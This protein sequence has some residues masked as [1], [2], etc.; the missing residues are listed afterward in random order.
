MSQF[1]TIVRE[2][3]TQLA[4]N[5]NFISYLNVDHEDGIANDTIESRIQIYGAN[6]IPTIPPK[7]IISIILNTLIDPL[8]FLL[9][10]SATIATVFG[11]VFEAQREN[12][13]WIEGIAIWFTITVI[14]FIGAYNDYK[15]DRA[16]HKLTTE[17]SS[18]M[19]GVIRDGVAQEISNEDL[20]VGDLVVLNAGDKVPT[21]GYLLQTF[22]LGVDESALT[23]ESIIVKKSFE[24]DPWFR[25]G[26]V[27]SEGY[28][29]MIVVAVGIESEYGRTLAL[30]HKE[31][32]KTPLQRRINR[33]VK[34]CGIVAM[35]VS[36]AVF[37]ALM[38]NWA[39]ENPRS[40]FDEGPLKFIVFSISIL[41]VGLPE[42][43]PAAVMITLSYS[44]K[45]MMKD[46]L[47]VR[48]LSACETLGSTT[49]LLSDK[50]G[51][52]TENK[53][54]VVRGIFGNIVFDT[55]PLPGGIEDIFEEVLKNCALNSTAYI[56]DNIGIGSQ[57]EIA[58]L[59]F[60]NTFDS[61]DKIR[62]SNVIDDFTPFSS[63]TKMSSALS[64]GKKYSKGSPEIIINNCSIVASADGPIEMNDELRNMYAG[65]VSE[66][67]STGLRTVALSVD[68]ILLGVFGIKDPVRQSVPFAVETCKQAGIGVMMV[69]GD[70]IHTAKHI[71]NDIG[72]LKHGDICLEG[73]EFR[74]MTKDAKL[75][76]AP[77]L[78]V[79]A[80]STPEDKY[81]LVKIMKELGHIVASSGDGAND[82][83]ALKEADVGCAMGTGTDLAKEASDIV[84]LT[85]DFDSIVNGVRWGRNIMANIRAFISFQVVINIVALTVVAVSAFAR[86]TTPL[87]VAQL[88][89]VNLVMDSFAAIGLATAPPT[90]DLMKKFPGSRNQ[91]V[92]TP[93]MLTSI[94]PH[95]VYQITAQLTIFFVAPILAD[96]TDKQLSGLMF[97]TFI[98]CQIFNILNVSMPD[99]AFPPIRM[100]KKPIMAVCAFGMIACQVIIMFLAKSIFKFDNITAN[101]WGISV[102]VGAGGSIIHAIVHGSIF[103]LNYE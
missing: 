94:I 92:I 78:R 52:L 26:S 103:W 55:S 74:K 16:F 38:I 47:F 7:T 58:M 23:G 53:M 63:T 93:T 28:G 2:R 59:R 21:D 101:M 72:M 43:L 70:N 10:F 44:I 30:V 79:L 20:L 3:D 68:N 66:M 33:F 6:K 88:L 39:S 76:I 45:K 31:S 99:S 36:A 57:T 56:K 100:Y 85:D 65:Y 27:V 25:S 87:N 18:Y 84:I 42:G 90:N 1:R 49:M 17:N 5:F 50:T 14:V 75:A 46:G 22:S 60:V 98:F 86:G 69:T 102:C 81:E 29:K 40:S 67:A 77:K 97:N 11:I 62:D 95:T 34:W 89:Y 96:I 80:R 82:A 15:Q 64:G 32:E 73:V 83:P 54:T 13:E 12:K 8:L 35:L 91:F 71:A 37:V 19:V 41:V 51:T 48:H 24:S 61:Y 4:N 9:A